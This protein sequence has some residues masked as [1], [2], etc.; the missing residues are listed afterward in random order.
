MPWSYNTKCIKL[1]WQEYNFILFLLAS[2]WLTFARILQSETFCVPRIGSCK[3]LGQ[4]LKT[5][6]F[7]IKALIFSGSW[8]RVIYGNILPTIKYRSMWGIVSWCKRCR[9][10]C[11]LNFILPQFTLL[12]KHP[13][14]HIHLLAIALIAMRLDFVDI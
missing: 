2:H 4:L 13:N 14:K 1:S 5:R 10:W 8:P 11:F 9:H 3:K 6:R 12:I 7:Y